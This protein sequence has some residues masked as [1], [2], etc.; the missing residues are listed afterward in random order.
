MTDSA[1]SPVEPL[2]VDAVQELHSAGQIQPYLVTV[3]SRATRKTFRSSSPRKILSSAFPRLLSTAR[4]A[5][6][7]AIYSAKLSRH[8]ATLDFDA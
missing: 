3:S 4:V 7:L 1:V 8:T 6:Q 5:Q 2:C